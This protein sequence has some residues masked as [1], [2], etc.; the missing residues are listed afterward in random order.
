M[1]SIFFILQKRKWG[2]V[3]GVTCLNLP[4]TAVELEFKP[5][6]TH[7]KASAALTTLHCPLPLHP[8]VISVWELKQGTVSSQ[9]SLDGV[10]FTGWLRFFSAP[11]MSTNDWKCLFILVGYSPPASWTCLVITQPSYV[12]SVC[13]NKNINTGYHWVLWSLSI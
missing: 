13:S 3:C 5:P 1:D 4:L 2:S 7:L 8:L 6:P 9:W 10:V 12:K 11:C